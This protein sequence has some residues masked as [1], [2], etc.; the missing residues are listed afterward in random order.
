MKTR[1]VILLSLVLSTSLLFVF[2]LGLTA[3]EGQVPQ[4][5]VFNT[6][7]S[8]SWDPL[9]DSTVGTVTSHIFEGLTIWEDGK[10]VLGAAEKIDISPDG[11]V[12]TIKLRDNLKWSD[13]QA[14]TAEDFKYGI[15][16]I[17]EPAL[18]GK[19]A[20]DSFYLKN[21]QAFNEGK[22][23]ADD[24]GIKV[25]DDK[26]LEMTLESPCGFFQSVLTYKN[27]YPLRKDIVEKD[28]NWWMKTDTMIGNGAFKMK[29]FNPGYK[30]VLVPN[31]NYREA[32]KVKLDTLEIRFI[33]D[34]QVELMAFK[35]N[36]IQVGILPPSDAVEE[37]K[38]SG[39]LYIYPKLQVYWLVMNNQASPVN[40]VKVRR[41]LALSIDRDAIVN[42]VLRGGQIPAYGMCP[43]IIND[44]SAD[45]PFRDVYPEYFEMDIPKAK[46]LLAEAGY[47]DGKGFPQ[48]TYLL[49]IGGDHAVIAQAIQ[50]MWKQNLGIEV[51]LEAL[52]SAVF[53]KE[54]RAVTYPIARYIW[55]TNI[56][57]P[58]VWLNLYISDGRNNDSKYVNPE[59]DKVIY[60]AINEPDVAKRF[61]LLHQAEKMLID[62]MGVI[63]LFYPMNKILIKKNIKDLDFTPAGG[64]L[65]K[66]AY[67]E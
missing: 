55:A 2:T 58:S 30:M 16:R 63:P 45:K 34:S 10:V 33:A 1:S 59:Y 49:S 42:K 51:D 44:V 35:A 19:Y 53:I 65:F 66:H 50:S 9:R 61:A 6:H 13:G 60:S 22:V 18:T 40:D 54:R 39:D 3:A 5:A 15:I 31:A 4:K 64:V 41:A 21:A 29:E 46:A 27:Y 48:T 23:K 62:D 57:D 56:P 17:L 8:E 12:Y 36:E 26:T 52:E 14:L 37:L 28:P 47:P 24:V 67:V 38:A 43:P 32:E 25:I 11:L 20:K 7:N